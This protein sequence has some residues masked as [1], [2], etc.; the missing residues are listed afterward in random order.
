MAIVL[1][2]IHSAYSVPIVNSTQSFPTTQWGDGLSQLIDCGDLS[3]LTGLEVN[4]WM[5]PARV[6]NN[7]TTVPIFTFLNFIEVDY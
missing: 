4:L 3:G 5:L 2:N 6:S 1:I 7:Q